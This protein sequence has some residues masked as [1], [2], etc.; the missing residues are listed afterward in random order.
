MTAQEANGRLPGRLDRGF[1]AAAPWACLTGIVQIAHCWLLLYR[2]TR[3]ARYL[4]AGRRANAYVRR[5]IHLDGNPDTRGGVKGA[6]PVDGDY[7]QWEFLNWAA[8]FC[9]D[10]N[11]IELEL[12]GEGKK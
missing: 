5:T 6:F 9:I 7:G 4:D 2:L 3:D 11:L 1:R 8:K 12:A 10:A